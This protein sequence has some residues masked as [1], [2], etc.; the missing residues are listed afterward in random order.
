MMSR[1]SLLGMFL[2]TQNKICRVIEDTNYT[3]VQLSKYFY[4]IFFTLFL[5][6]NWN[7]DEK[8]LRRCGPSSQRIFWEG[9][10]FS[11]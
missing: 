9:Y 1:G 4:F 5:T 8:N 10:G 11:I 2:N 3:E 6:M 7:I